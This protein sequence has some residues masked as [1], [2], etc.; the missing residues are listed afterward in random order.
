MQKKGKRK[1]LTQ[2]IAAKTLKILGEKASKG[3]KNIDV[4]SHSS[5]AGPVRIP[6]RFFLIGSIVV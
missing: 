5:A 6:S 2:R 3:T 1:I 4:Q